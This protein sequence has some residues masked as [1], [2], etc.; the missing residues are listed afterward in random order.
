MEQLIFLAFLGLIG[1]V[2]LFLQAAEKK[3]NAEAARQAP[4]A[5]RPNAPVQRA[6]AQTEE[7]RVRRFMEALGVPTSTAPTPKAPP[8]TVQPRKPLQRKIQPV[9]SFP[10]PRASTFT[11]PPVAP[12]LPPVTVPAPGPPIPVLAPPRS[13]TPTRA[14]STFEVADVSWKTEE[15]PTGDLATR[16]AVAAADQSWSA[17]L[18]QPRALRDAIILREIFGPP[19]SLQPVDLI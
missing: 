16:P 12:T 14:A 13:A 2:K 7:E 17:R 3:R 18:A 1:L 8:R 5:A 9:D 4:D 6:P 11:K 10:A 19:R 15:A